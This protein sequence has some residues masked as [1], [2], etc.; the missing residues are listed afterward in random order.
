MTR[1]IEKKTQ[2]LLSFQIVLITMTIIE[3]LSDQEIYN[4]F[5]S[6]LKR[7]IRSVLKSPNTT[8]QVPRDIIANY[9]KLLHKTTQLMD[10]VGARIPDPE[11][12]I[13]VSRELLKWIAHERPDLLND[14]I[15]DKEIIY[16]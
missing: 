1:S 11:A 12:K 5:F 6:S 7:K 8:Y 16:Q 15:H 14:M 9:P 2:S 13:I 10:S 3:P 4:N